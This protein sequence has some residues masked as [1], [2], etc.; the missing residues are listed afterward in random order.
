MYYNIPKTGERTHFHRLTYESVHLRAF[1]DPSPPP[2]PWVA[3][4]CSSSPWSEILVCGES[5][6]ILFL[7]GGRRIEPLSPQTSISE[8]GEPENPNN[9]VALYDTPHLINGMSLYNVRS[10]SI[11][12]S[13]DTNKI[14]V[15][16]E[17]RDSRFERQKVSGP[18]RD[19]IGYFYSWG[20]K[21]G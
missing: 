18:G 16:Y 10:K 7:P 11:F 1:P 17:G 2:T 20:V 19:Q 4:G 14:G 13:L 9:Q 5:G 3:G 8:H 6:S 21:W 12:L 15:K